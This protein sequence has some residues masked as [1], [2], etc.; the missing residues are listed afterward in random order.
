MARVLGNSGFTGSIPSSI[1]NL[2]KMWRWLSAQNNLVGEIPSTIGSCTQLQSFDSQYNHHTGQIPDS[3][4]ALPMLTEVGLGANSMAGEIPQSCFLNSARSLFRLSIGL[5]QLSGS[6]PACISKLTKLQILYLDNN[7]LTGTLPDDIGALSSLQI[8]YAHNNGLSGGIPSSLGN[9]IKLNKLRL[10]SNSL[11]GSV[12]NTFANLSQLQEFN[13]SGNCLTGTLP[14]NLLVQFN[15]IGIQRTNC[16]APTPTPPPTDNSASQSSVPIAAIAGGVA[17]GV[18]V[19][20]AIVVGLVFFLRKRKMGSGDG[21]LVVTGHEN[22]KKHEEA[23]RAVQSGFDIGSNGNMAPLMNKASDPFRPMSFNSNTSVSYIPVSTSTYE[24]TI[25]TPEPTHFVGEMKSS[26][27]FDNAYPV[28]SVRRFQ[29]DEKQSYG[30]REKIIG[31]QGLATMDELN[32]NG[33]HIESILQ[34]QWGPYFKWNCEQVAMWAKEK[35]LDEKFLVMLK[36]N[37]VDGAVLHSIDRETLKSDLEITDLKT[38]AKVLKA[39]ELL[40]ESLP[41]VSSSAANVGVGGIAGAVFNTHDSLGRIAPP[42]YHMG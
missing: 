13:V 23:G 35:M 3:L 34:S 20:G 7:G 15:G 18:L 12:P 5:N 25:S 28:A 22:L 14:N 29:V 32:G 40:R 42:A 11:S 4:A 37:E 16:I 30:V 24:T 19:I 39:I 26:G 10:D 33:N 6:I 21:A 1:G 9:A 41:K 2:K 31:L 8:F 27:L 38:R 36:E 17:G